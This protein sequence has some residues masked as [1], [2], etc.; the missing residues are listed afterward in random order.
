MSN[1]TLTL[2]KNGEILVTS[3]TIYNLYPTLNK[4]AVQAKIKRCLKRGDLQRLYKGVYAVDPELLRKPLSAENVAHLIDH[5]AFLSGLAA[6]RFHNLIPETINYK[7]FTGAK[8]AKIYSKNINF[9]IKKVSADQLSF[10]IQTVN[11]GENQIRVA[12]MIRA[13][14]DTLIE[15]KLNL[16][17]RNQICAFLRIDEDDS[18][19]IP[20]KNA[21]NYA[22]KYKN[23]KLAK[24]VAHAMQ[25]VEL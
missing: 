6:L 5:K 8:S 23:S 1:L 19:S 3:D 12:D 10:G 20:W 13:I 4:N 18:E 7:T 21:E 25:I 24:K 14:M 15:Q 9:E 2:I 11:I 17:N 16:K 22:Y